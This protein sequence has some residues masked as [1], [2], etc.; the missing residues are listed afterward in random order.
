MKVCC[1]FVSIATVRRFD[2]AV[3]NQVLIKALESKAY[4]ILTRHYSINSI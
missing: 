2:Y 1:Y 3:S 4:L